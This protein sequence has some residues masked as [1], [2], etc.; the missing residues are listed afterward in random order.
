MVVV[1][2]RR[3]TKD[4]NSPRNIEPIEKL[5]KLLLA[6]QGLR[7]TGEST[8]ESGCKFSDIPGSKRPRPYSG[9]V[10]YPE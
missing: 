7:F 5:E 6:D 3:A 2:K 10:T 4:L 8:R 9:P 1:R